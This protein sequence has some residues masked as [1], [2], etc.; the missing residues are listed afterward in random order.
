MACHLPSGSHCDS[1]PDRLPG[2]L[3][4]GCR[5]PPTA[6]GRARGG[7][8][9]HLAGSAPMDLSS[10]TIGAKYTRPVLARRWGYESHHTLGR[11]VATPQ[12][13]KVVL[14][15]VTPVKQTSQ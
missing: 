4:D 1:R 10:L 12:G 14:L 11:G 3:P 13:E 6:T 7:A 8:A 15:L 5:P 9:A 2:R